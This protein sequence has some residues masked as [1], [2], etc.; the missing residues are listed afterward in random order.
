MAAITDEIKV[1]TITVEKTLETVLD[2]LTKRKAFAVLQVPEKQAQLLLDDNLQQ[3]KVINAL[4]PENADCDFGASANKDLVPITSTACASRLR[5]TD[6]K[7]DADGE[8]LRL[9][10]CTY[11]CFYELLN[12]Q[13][14]IS[15]DGTRML[16]YVGHHLYS[17]DDGRRKELVKNELSGLRIDENQISFPTIRELYDLAKNRFLRCQ[18][19]G[20]NEDEAALIWSAI[21]LG[22]GNDFGRYYISY[23]KTMLTLSLQRTSMASGSAIGHDEVDG[24]VD[25]S[26][27]TTYEQIF[28]KMHETSTTRSFGYDDDIFVECCIRHDDVATRYLFIELFSNH[29]WGLDPSSLVEVKVRAEFVPDICDFDTMRFAHPTKNIRRSNGVP[30][31]LKSITTENAVEPKFKVGKNREDEHT[32]NTI[33]AN[34]IWDNVIDFYVWLDILLGE[35]E[36]L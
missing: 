30:Y 20:E 31:F 24:P 12:N 18:I 17:R 25:P 6:N 15:T 7:V 9:V 13:G 32:D 16:L 3:R 35:I 2:L 23:D 21:H 29:N 28:S 1:Y 36:L 5:S 22:L 14:S 8:D 34:R 26:E 4:K 10:E 11:G 33:A 19:Y 27:F